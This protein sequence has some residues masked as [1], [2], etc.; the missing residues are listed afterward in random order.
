[1][2]IEYNTGKVPDLDL[3]LVGIFVAFSCG[4]LLVSIN[5]TQLYSI[6]YI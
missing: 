3:D 6:Y 1:V 5:S 4:L 2:L